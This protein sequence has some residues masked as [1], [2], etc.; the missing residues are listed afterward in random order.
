M[1]ILCVLKTGFKQ[2][3]KIYKA[4]YSSLCSRETDIQDVILTQLVRNKK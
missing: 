3:N 1:L 4:Q 2:I